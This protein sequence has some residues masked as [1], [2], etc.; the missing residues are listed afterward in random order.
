MMAFFRD[1]WVEGEGGM[2]RRMVKAARM[3]GAEVRSGLRQRMTRNPDGDRKRNR[4]ESGTA[5]FDATVQDLRYALR[6]VRRSPA[7]SSVVMVTLALGLGATTA[8]FGVLRSVVLAPLPFDEPDRLIRLYE[9][10]KQ[11]PD[12]A[13][14]V[15]GPAF[16]HLREHSR[17]L[18]DLAAI[19]TYAA[20]GADVMVGGRPERMRTLQVSSDYFSLLR[21]EP[22]A[23]RTFA[24]DEERADARLAVMS[25]SAWQQLGNGEPWSAGSTI[26]LDGASHDVIGVMPAGFEDPVGGEIDVWVPVALAGAD[27]WE[28]WQ[29]DNHW[30]TVIGRLAPGTS[31]DA[32]RRE[33]TALSLQQEE[34]APAVAEYTFRLHGLQQ[35]LLGNSDTLLYLLMGAVLFLLL[36]AC[37]NIASLYLARSLER[38]PELAVRTVLGSPRL[39][40]ARQFVFEALLLACGGALLGSALAL[41]LLRVLLTLAPLELRSAVTPFDPAVFGFGLAVA[42]ACGLL[43][44]AAPAWSV[45]RAGA[46]R[47]LRASGR[48]GGARSAARA[49]QILTVVQVAL[50]LVLVVGAGLL[51]ASVRRLQQA[52][53]GFEPGRVLTFEVNLPESRY[54]ESPTRAEFHETLPRRLAELPG[55]RSVGAVSWLPVTGRGFIWGTWLG[56]ATGRVADVSLGADQ[57]VITGAYFDAAGIRLLRG[58]AFGPEDGP[59]APGRA[60]IN[61]TLADRLFPESDALSARIWVSGDGLDVVGIVADA[62]HD[63]RGATSPVVYH[64]YAQ[65]AERRN[66]S[67][68]YVIA[69]NGDQPG[70]V[71]DVRS[72]LSSIDP[73][74]VVHAPEPLAEVVGKGTARERFAMRLLGA[75]AALAVVLAALGIYGVLA[76]A[77]QR[78]RREIGIRLALGAHAPEIRRMIVL[79]GVGLAA[80][81]IAVG[82][83]GALALA[84]LLDSFLYGTSALDP[85]VFV[86]AAASVIAIAAVASWLPSRTATRVSPA[87]AFRA[88]A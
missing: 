24:R 23:G 16:E 47:V 18:S 53:L 34:L 57:R 88:E 33:V 7:F 49:R 45:W 71:E 11:S 83:L 26:I 31:M 17:S 22:V 46:A 68:K 27:G 86:S 2:A 81:G 8:V 60:V 25:E 3:S 1:T 48:G 82:V 58:R 13:G 36:I 12:E 32:A 85:R 15:T 78:R 65:F 75:F 10:S 72:M 41:G 67:M 29:W 21:I 76:N 73:E 66:W 84:R 4:D 42:L 19:Y 55:V 50:A 70:L 44:G 54:G 40:L 56:T 80:M 28:N 74:L 61:Q 6:A 37:V 5:R 43:F 62:A 77:V 20:T 63:A 87:E 64:P 35:D 69:Q 59:D 38:G 39:R 30:L 14:Y 9:P 51:I 79:Q 52:D